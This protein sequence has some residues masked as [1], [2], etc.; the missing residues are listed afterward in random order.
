MIP[1]RGGQVFRHPIP[2]VIAPPNR[3]CV[4]LYIPDQIDHIAAF[5]GTLSTLFYWWNWER[6]EEHEATL[7]AQVWHEVYEDARQRWLRGEC[8]EECEDC[9]P[10]KPKPPVTGGGVEVGRLGFTLEQLEDFFMGSWLRGQLAWIDGKLMFAGN[11]CDE[12]C[13]VPVISGSAPT[14]LSPE[15]IEALSDGSLGLTQWQENGEPSSSGGQSPIPSE[16]P[17]YTTSDSNACAKAS[18]F[19]DEMHALLIAVRDGLEESSA[20]TIQQSGLITGILFYTGAGSLPAALLSAYNWFI[21]QMVGRSKAETVSQINDT[22]DDSDGWTAS[23]CELVGHMQP[24]VTVGGLTGN[25]ATE[26]DY[27]ALITVLRDQVPHG[28]HVDQI[29]N[30]FPLSAFLDGVRQRLPT[31]ECKCSSFLPFGYIP[32]SSEGTIMFKELIYSNSINS[33]T[34]P[35]AYLSG[36][37]FD[38]I[39]LSPDQGQHL[40]TY[41][42]RTMYTGADNSGGQA[43]KYTICALLL[44]FPA[45]IVLDNVKYDV[46]IIGTPAGGVAQEIQ[47]SIAGYEVAA[48]WTGE[49]HNSAA[50]LTDAS[51]AQV[52]ASGAF[53]ACTHLAIAWK[54]RNTNENLYAVLSNIRITG[55]IGGSGFL[56]KLI[57]ETIP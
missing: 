19:I 52:T 15:A 17:F 12:W 51:D 36:N 20:A 57:G 46:D 32:P 40:G 18:A 48:G 39:Q 25:R 30:T 49:V 2:A 38:L 1:K 4:T 55:N 9:P 35:L 24:M 29:Y 47:C 44:E 8:G 31:Q 54:T 16:N 23:Y 34:T 33:S 14:S 7:A 3:R 45:A 50:A 56:N 10:P 27:N 26:K 41:S 6:N 22:L 11:G 13:E 28:T 53:D 37:P 21:N 43:N 42:F 5:W